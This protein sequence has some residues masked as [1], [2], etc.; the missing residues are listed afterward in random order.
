[1]AIIRIAICD[2]EILFADK[3]KK[4]VASYCIQKQIPYKVD[5]YQHGK[6]FL[7]DKIKMTEYQIVFLDINMKEISGLKIAREIR[8][9]CPKTYIIFVT[10]FINYSLEG[11]KVDAI[12]YILKT[13]TYFQRAV[14]E[15]LDAVF[16][17]MQYTSVIK[18]FKF[19]EGSRNIALERIIYIESTL[20]KLMFY[21]MDEEIVLYTM[22]ETLNNI[23]KGFTKDFIR[24]HQ[25]YL[26][27]LKFV[28]KIVGNELL[29][30]NNISLP[31][32]RSKMKEVKSR[33]AL[34]KGDI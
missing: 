15:S 28:T 16:T 23:S 33:V 17:K 14:Y 29:M 18:N 8:T 21:I 24:I 4:T 6:T 19:Q 34:Y 26:A 12:R 5:V 3:L 11:Y 9:L 32:S 22:Y 30:F 31:I 2:D 20:H 25:S 7:T 1:M 10:A 13:D 27:N